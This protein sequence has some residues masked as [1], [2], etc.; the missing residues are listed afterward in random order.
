MIENLIMS[1]FTLRAILLGAL[2]GFSEILGQIFLT[3]AQY[4]SRYS[5]GAHRHSSKL[6]WRYAEMLSVIPEEGAWSTTLAA[7]RAHCLSRAHC[8]AS[9]AR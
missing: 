5:T 7:Q 2:L 8:K 9:A 4:E 3:N 6:R 1:S